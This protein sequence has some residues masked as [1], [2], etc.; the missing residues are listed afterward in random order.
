MEP[1]FYKN[2]TKLLYLFIPTLWN[3]FLNYS[4]FVLFCNWTEEGVDT[5]ARNEGWEEVVKQ[6]WRELS[7][8]S[9]SLILDL[10]DLKWIISLIKLPNSYPLIMKICE[11]KSLSLGDSI[12][13]TKVVTLQFTTS[14]TNAFCVM[15]SPKWCYY[16]EKT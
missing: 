4:N 5:S 13:Y 10:S 2:Y 11:C 12:V 8:F 9:S 7:P 14:E 15:Y 16:W 3:L 1:H 6:I